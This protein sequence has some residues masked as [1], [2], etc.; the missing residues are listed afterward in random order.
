MTELEQLHK[1]LD[2]EPWNW[3]NL[4]TDRERHEIT[5][6]QFYARNLSHGTAGHNRLILIAKL[7]SMLDIITTADHDTE[8]VS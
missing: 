1:L 8:T 7:V 2:Q 6:A 5:L 3:A 4:L